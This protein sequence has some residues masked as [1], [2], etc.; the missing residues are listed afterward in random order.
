MIKNYKIHTSILT[1]EEELRSK[2][3]TFLEREI[4]DK[5]GKASHFIMFDRE[6]QIYIA[7]IDIDVEFRFFRYKNRKIEVR[8]KDLYFVRTQNLNWFGSL[9]SPIYKHPYEVT[10]ITAAEFEFDQ[11]RKL[12]SH[13]SRYYTEIARVV[14]CGD[15]VEIEF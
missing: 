15:H 14:D 7:T 2:D 5:Y 11:N 6:Y 12:E 4:S 9:D 3:K 13:Q 10:A 1:R 8:G